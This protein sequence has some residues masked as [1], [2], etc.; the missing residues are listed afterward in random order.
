MK[1]WVDIKATITP[2]RVIVAFT[3]IIELSESPLPAPRSYR[4]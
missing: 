4:L 3:I 1:S 2:N